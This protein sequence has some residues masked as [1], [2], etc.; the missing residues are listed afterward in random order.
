VT[1]RFDAALVDTQHLSLADVDL[2]VDGTLVRI[3]LP[4][5]A[6]LPAA[7]A[8]APLV[9]E[10]QLPAVV[11]S[12]TATAKFHRASH[13]LKVALQAAVSTATGSAT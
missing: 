5:S 12:D 2:E 13:T 11:D 8:T 9:V 4:T 6:L 1:F 10:A 3:T 7:A